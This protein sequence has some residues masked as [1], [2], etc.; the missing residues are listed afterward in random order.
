MEQIWGAIAAVFQ[1]W[2]NARA[3]TYRRL[4]NIPDEW[5]RLSP[6]RRWCSAIWAKPARRGLPSRAIRRRAKTRFT[7]NFCQCPGR[8]CCR[9]LAHTAP[10]DARGT[11]AVRH[12]RSFIAGAYAGDLR[13]MVDVFGRL[14]RI[15]AICRMSSSPCKTANCLFCRHAAAKRT[16]RAAIKIA[17]DMVA[18]GQIDDDEACCAST[19]L[20]LNNY[21]TRHWTVGEN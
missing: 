4:H 14:R 15:S 5:A 13:E 2:N 8:G 20:R 9:G 17:V 16:T 18:A 1:S 6:C 10:F 3:I 19:R 7:V 11:R 21:C 12:D